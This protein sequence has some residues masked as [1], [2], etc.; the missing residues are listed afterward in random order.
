[1]RHSL[2]KN[3]IGESF[4]TKY[5]HFKISAFNNSDALIVYISG[6]IDARVVE[7]AI[8]ESLMKYSK[9]PEGKIQNKSKSNT[10][11]LMENGVFTTAVK[12]TKLWH[13]ICD[14][15]IEGD[16]A[17]FIENSETALILTT[18]KY[19]ERAITEPETES[20]IRSPRDGFTENIQTNAS[21]IRR[22]IKDYGLRFYNMK[23][24]DAL[25]NMIAI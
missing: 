10:S 8:L 17:L 13:E 2:L 4:D 3:K 23:I 6:M 18:R 12:E 15:V 1:M 14:V 22:R 21:L 19:A 20:E 11:V 16:T 5:R 9:L 24:G 25:I 7:E